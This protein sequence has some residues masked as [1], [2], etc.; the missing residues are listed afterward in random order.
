MAEYITKVTNLPPN[1]RY[2]CGHDASGKSIFL[3]SPEQL[4]RG[5][6]GTGGV[7]RSFAVGTV[8][9]ILTNDE[10]VRKYLDPNKDQNTLS[11]KATDIV[12]PNSTQSPNGAN[13]LVVDIAPGGESQ[14]HQTVSIDFSIC[15]VG[16]I[17][18]ELDSGEK[19][20]LSPGV[21]CSFS[22]ICNW[23]CF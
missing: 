2:I 8:P 20:N 18:M 21:S 23:H 6:P 12:I 3:P 5:A 14:M 9:A 22:T 7:A 4:Y 1:K 15:V 19:V 13:L 16:S 10:D 17:N 11:F